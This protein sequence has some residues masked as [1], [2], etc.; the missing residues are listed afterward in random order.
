MKLEITKDFAFAHGGNRV[1]QYMAG[2]SVE[3]DDPEL[4]E[5]ATAEGWAK[6]AGD[7]SAPRRKALKGAPE[8]K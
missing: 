6:V 3:T 5:V 1:V 2:Q 8:N 4:V 7:D